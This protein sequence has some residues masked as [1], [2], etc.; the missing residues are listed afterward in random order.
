ML[1][2][3]AFDPSMQLDLEIARINRSTIG[4]KWESDLRAG[5]VGEYVEVIDVDPA[6]QCAYEGVDLDDPHLLAERGLTPSE[7]NPQFHQ[8]MVYAVAMST[9][10]NFEE[11]LGRNVHWSP[12]RADTGR[13]YRDHYVRRL[14]IYPHALREANAYYSPEKKAL[15]FGY[16]NSQNED[17]REG[18]PGGVVFTC[19]SY[20]VIAHEMT[21]AI[22]DGIHRR[23]IEPTNVD[24]LAFHEAFADLI[25]I[26]QHFTLPGVLEME[27]QKTRGDL[28]TENLLS[29]LALQFGRATKYGPALRDALGGI[30]QAGKW[31][32]N[33]PDP[34]KIRQTFEP[35]ARGAILVAAV[36]DAFLA[37]YQSHTADLLRIASGGTGILQHGALHP[38]VVK[39]LA[40]EAATVA[41]RMLNIC[42]RALDY[43]PPVD[44]NFGDYLRAMITSDIANMPDDRRHYRTAIIRAFRDRG[45]YPRDV[46]TLSEESLSWLQPSE[47]QQQLLSRILPDLKGIRLM[48]NARGYSAEAYRRLKEWW[49]DP[50]I[51]ERQMTD[52]LVND[53]SNVEAP[54]PGKGLDRQLQWR[55]ERQFARYLHR[56]LQRRARR[57][58]ARSPRKRE[59][60]AQLLGIDVCDRD[61]KFEVHAVRPI[62]RRR[63][64]GQTKFELLVLITQRSI[65]TLPDAPGQEPLQYRFRSGCTLLID[66]VYGHV[67]YCIVKRINSQ[68]RKQRQEAFLRQR[69]RREGV[70]ARARYGL[71][72]PHERDA[73]HR[74]PQEPFRMVHRGDEGDQWP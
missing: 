52:A 53:Y 57:L 44:V 51:S 64:N 22:L 18:L 15:L 41:Q 62:L 23:M 59:A 8:Q 40:D 3:F 32:R 34:Q 58:T 1:Q 43:L 71:W 48:A 12:R 73:A 74:V 28:T 25:A 39:R 17:A 24:S 56:V 20:D 2:V 27:I 70:S 13:L 49:K 31:Q 72:S 7:G 10:A 38:D 66:P 11:A 21:H 9:I 55:R 19:L 54:Q 35:H 37:N 16:F 67:E 42:I 68:G 33:A 26:F 6:S 30:D 36:F 65:E 47:K 46:R 50:G 4:V 14:R 69:L 29:K 5:P 45:I 61:R 60:L 63:P